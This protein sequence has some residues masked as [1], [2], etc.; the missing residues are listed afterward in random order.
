MP[1]S[2]DLCTVW[3]CQ[4]RFASPALPSLSC[5]PRVPQKVQALPIYALPVT[6]LPYPALRRPILVGSSP[7][8]Q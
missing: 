4:L 2:Y 6:L 5:K 3:L 7:D 8:P 1:M